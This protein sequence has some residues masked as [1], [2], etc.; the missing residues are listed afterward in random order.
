M[1]DN[2]LIL[3]AGASVDSGIPVLSRF[4]DKMIEYSQ[5]PLD[6]KDNELFKSVKDLTD[7][8]IKHHRGAV[9]NDRNIEDVLSM[10]SFLKITDK[11]RATKLFDDLTKCISKTIEYS[12]NLKVNNGV[13]GVLKTKLDANIWAPLILANGK[14]YSIPSILTFNYDLVLERNLISLF[15]HAEAPNMGIYKLFDELYR[16]EQKDIRLNYYF[17]KNNSIYLK[18]KTPE[19]VKPRSG[20]EFFQYE[21]HES[22]D[23]SKNILDINLLK[24]HGS[25]NFSNKEANYSKP[26][27]HSSKDPFILPPIFNK[28]SEKINKVWEQAMM[29]LSKAKTITFIGY[30]MPKTDIYLQYFLK[31]AIGANSDIERINI[32]DPVLF[33]QNENANQMKQ[34]YLDCFANQLHERIF[35]EP[36]IPEAKLELKDYGGKLRHFNDMLFNTPELL[37]YKKPSLSQ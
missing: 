13:Y 9:F 21:L 37:F 27:Y 35:F 34:R 7:Y 32:F 28:D 20:L 16:L 4:F 14:G 8:L 11:E 24:L 29:A 22:D 36:I 30:S 5:I 33:M 19:N 1:S 18:Y 23:Q 25:V 10:L 26:F 12:C 17:G 3:G 31:S 2:V 6:D 15:Q